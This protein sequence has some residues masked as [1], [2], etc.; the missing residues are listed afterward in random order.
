MTNTVPAL[1][2]GADGALWFGTALGL[3]RFHDGQFTPVLFNRQPAVSDHVATLEQ[4]FQDVAAAIFAARP[5][6]TVALGEV[7]FV[8]AFGRALVKED[9]IFSA[10]E[11]AQGRLWVGTLGGGLRRIECG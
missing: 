7:S 1:V 2:V 3:T 4:F 9:L 11:D 8:E 10:V 5:L 6:T